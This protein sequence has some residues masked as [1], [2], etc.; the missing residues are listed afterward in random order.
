MSDR[1]AG[2]GMWTKR[3][4]DTHACVPP[5]YEIDVY[6]GDQ[7]KCDCGK[8]YLVTKIVER[9]RGLQSPRIKWVE[10]FESGYIPPGGF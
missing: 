3:I 5:P 4:I 1:R 9:G 8:S 10:L 7:W 2:S 6:V